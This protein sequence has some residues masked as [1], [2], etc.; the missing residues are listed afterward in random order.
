VE[1]SNTEGSKKHIGI[2]I[3][4][5]IIVIIILPDLIPIKMAVKL[6][7]GSNNSEKLFICT[8]AVTTG[9][10]WTLIGDENGLFPEHKGELVILNG[11][12]PNKIRT[13]LQ[14]GC[15]AT[16]I[17]IVKGKVVG[18]DD[19]GMKN[20]HFKVIEVTDWS[21]GYPIDRGAMIFRVLSP[22]RYLTIYDYLG[23]R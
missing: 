18:E 3:V 2:F 9:P 22:K 12:V 10:D 21:V 19:Y 14:G 5:A 17:Y 11:N 7:N 13:V 4:I 6:S 20:E 23:L 1:K 15:E 16:N 8:E